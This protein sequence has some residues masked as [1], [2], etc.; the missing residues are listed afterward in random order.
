MA[1]K[2]ELA[3]QLVRRG[4]KTSQVAAQLRC[5][6]FFVRKIRNCLYQKEGVAHVS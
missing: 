3:A 1:Q 6:P 2:E 5:S 4:L